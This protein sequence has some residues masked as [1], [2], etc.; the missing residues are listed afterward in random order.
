MEQAT[1]QRKTITIAV[2]GT[3]GKREFKDV[4]IAPGTRPRDILV[5]LG[6]P[7]LNLTN[8]NG[9]LFDANVD[10][11]GQVADGQKVYAAQSKAEAG[12]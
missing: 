12:R 5:K 7:G 1:L 2:A 3:D 10:L 4:A 6:L 9:G 11:F 8:P